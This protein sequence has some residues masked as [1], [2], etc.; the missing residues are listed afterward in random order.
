M[1][2]VPWQDCSGGVP[3]L[4]SA[5]SSKDSQLPCL[6]SLFYLLATKL[7]HLYIAE[8]DFLATLGRGGEVLSTSYPI[9]KPAN[10]WPTVHGLFGSSKLRRVTLAF[11]GT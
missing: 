6:T 10:G 4:S 8:K 2:F 9:K 11:C 1:L 5:N 7:D 3:K